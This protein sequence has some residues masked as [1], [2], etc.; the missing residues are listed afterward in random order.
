MKISRLDHL[1]LTVRD[2]GAACSFYSLVLGMEVVTFGGGRKA[3]L[4]GSQKINLHEKDNE[5]EPKPQ[6]PTPGSA[7]LCF[8]SETPLDQVVEYLREQNVPIEEGPVERT[9]A[10]GKITSLYIRDPD[11]NLIEISTYGVTISA[12]ALDGRLK[13]LFVDNHARFAG[14]TARTFLSAH[15]VTIVSDMEAA[16]QELATGSFDIMLVDYDLDDGQGADLVL[17]VAPLAN[18][19]AIIATSAHA[20][21]NQALLEAGADAI[22]SKMEFKKIEAVMAGALARRKG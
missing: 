8:I 9:G 10:T 5:F 11:G 16:R 20:P 22:C 6:T 3:L 13:I 19:P 21:G 15:D 1:V 2:V 14:I 12:E 4:F 7:D 18:R 17:E